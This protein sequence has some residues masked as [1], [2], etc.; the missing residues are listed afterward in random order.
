MDAVKQ[1]MAS[2]DAAWK[3]GI[4]VLLV[5]LAIM[6]FSMASWYKN[7]YGLYRSETDSINELLGIRRHILQSAIGPLAPNYESVCGHLAGK[8]GIYRQIPE[9]KTALVNWRPLSVRMAGYLGGHKTV[10]DGVFDMNAGIQLALQCGARC[11]IFDID[12]LEDRPCEPRLI[13]RDDQGVMRSLHTGSISHGMD[14]L[15]R[16]AFNTN[17]DPVIVVVYFRRIPVGKTQQSTFMKAVAAAL[18]PLSTY[19]LGSTEQGNFHNC[20]SESSLF[21]SEITNFQKK[22]IVLCNYNTN[23]LPS[24][25]NP[26]DNLDFW[27]NA[28][29]YVDPSGASA[30]LGSI[31]ASVPNGQ[32]AYAKVGSTRQLLQIPSDSTGSPTT[33]NYVTNTSNTFTIALSSM[34]DVFTTAEVATLLN[35]LGIQSVPLDVLR[36]ATTSEHVKS[37]TNPVQPGRINDLANAMNPNDPLSFWLHAGWSRKLIIEGFQDMKPVPVASNI[38]GFVIPKAVVPKKPPPSTNSNGVLVNIGY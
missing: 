33:T 21:T 28:R 14:S 32:V 36:L 15:N 17:Y 30:L 2:P 19:H 16:M 8:R 10:R 5:I 13:H 18:D 34:E 26:K 12:Y 20:R 1:A 25:P 9:D 4:P 24:T 38:P 35:R 7:E 11:F 27:T 29:L 37:K 6:Y 23:L 3:I 31:T 22:F